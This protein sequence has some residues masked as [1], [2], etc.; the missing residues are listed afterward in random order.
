MSNFQKD[1]QLLTDL[2]ELISDAE[3]TANMPGYA[4]AVFNAISPA[5]KAAMPAA[6][7]K[8]RRQI[9]V[10]TR[11]KRTADGADGGTA[12]MTNGDFIRSMSDADIRENFTQLLC[13]FVQREQTS[14]CRSREHCFHC[15]KDWLKEE[16]V[17]LRRADDDTE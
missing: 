1:V 3:R 9:D 12:E 2:Q 11:A 8:A 14:R 4:G 7:K 15:I 13:E 16:S 10:L 6:Q 5:L 17:A